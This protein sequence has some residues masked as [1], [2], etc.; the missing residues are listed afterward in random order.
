MLQGVQ[1]EVR[2]GECLCITGPTGSGK[3]TLLLAIKNLLPQGRS[4]G[5]IVS[6][7]LEH[8]FGVGTGLVLQNPET[9]LMANTVGAE[10][11][12]GLENICVPPEKMTPMILE[13]LS[14]VGLDLPLDFPVERLSMGQKYRLILASVL[15][16]SPSLVLLDEPGAQLDPEGISKLKQV[17]LKLKTRGMG[18]ILC[19]HHPHFF[20]EVINALYGIDKDGAIKPIPPMAWKEKTLPLGAKAFPGKT[21][22]DSQ[23]LIIAESI[24]AR[25]YESKPP[26][27]SASFSI[28]RGQRMGIYGKNGSG[29]TTLLRCITG[30]LPLVSGKLTVFGKKTAP[31][32]LRG[33]TG[34]L[35]QNP[36]KQLFENTV[37]DE[38]AFP[39]KRLGLAPGEIFAKV[40]GLLRTLGMEDLAEKSPH[41]LS[42]GQKHLVVLASALVFAPELVILDDPFAGLDDAWRAKIKSILT[43][44]FIKN[45]MTLI[46][47]GHHEDELLDVADVVFDI[48]GGNLVPR[49]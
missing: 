40:H 7:T 28:T 6:T 26:W 8:T 31:K 25:G 30:F 42:F 16:M 17:L 24:C 41:K 1:L 21:P 9:Q 46:W 38:V 49:R 13:A 27:S 29:K 36:Q 12:F 11:A 32:H 2:A 3:S 14:A 4:S 5:R 48:T 35:F 39:L 15:V 10:V 22:L 23:P 43:G 19:E 34:C 44:S 47:T 37:F 20:S 33:K 18:V 45:P